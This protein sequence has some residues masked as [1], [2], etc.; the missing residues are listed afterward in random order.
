MGWGDWGNGRKITLET[1]QGPRLEKTPREE[2]FDEFADSGEGGG[3][4][5]APEGKGNLVKETSLGV[6]ERKEKSGHLRVGA[7]S[8]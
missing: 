7:A 6:V 2:P 4:Q 5:C 8:S 1:N 3:W